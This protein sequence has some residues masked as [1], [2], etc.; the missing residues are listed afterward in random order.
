LGF[1]RMDIPVEKRFRVLSQILRASHFEWLRAARALAPN[2]SELQLILKFWEEVAKDTAES[3]IKRIE[4]DKP[5]PEQ[6]VRCFV[7]SSICMGEDCEAVAGKDENEAFAR[8]TACPWFE[9]HKRLGKT[10]LDLPGC[11]RWIEVFV[12][13]INRRLG[14]RVRWE[15]L[16]ALPKGDDV[17]L[18][19]F[20]VE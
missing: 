6:I 8:H 2:V 16:K 12:D 13:E 15:T 14:V 9:W 4:P 20:W 11:D 17:C 18:R 1:F 19:R 3:Y 10:E 5:L 7:F